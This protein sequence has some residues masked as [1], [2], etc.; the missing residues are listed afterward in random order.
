MGAGLGLY[1][2]GAGLSAF[3]QSQRYG[4]WMLPI[5]PF[6]FLA[7][8]ISYGLGTLWGLGSLLT[9]RAPV[10]GVGAQ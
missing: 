4:W 8:H 5:L 2:V 3:Q 9:R 1:L 10:Q 7:Y 6:L